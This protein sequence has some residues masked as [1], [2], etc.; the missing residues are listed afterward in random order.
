MLLLT[1]DDDDTVSPNNSRNLH[2]VLRKLGNDVTL[3]EYPG[4]GHYGIVLG[5][6]SS[7]DWNAQVRK[8]IAAFIVDS[9]R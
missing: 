1:G 2:A 7:V 6:V 3:K 8:D 9:A 4:V 5:L